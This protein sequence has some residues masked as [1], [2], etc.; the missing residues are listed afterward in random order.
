MFHFILKLLSNINDGRI[1]YVKFCDG[2]YHWA[3]LE[4]KSVYGATGRL[5][6]EQTYTSVP[7]KYEYEAHLVKGYYLPFPLDKQ[8]KLYSE[9]SKKILHMAR[10]ENDRLCE[11]SWPI[12]NKQ[13]NLLKIRWEREDIVYTYNENGDLSRYNVHGPWECEVLYD[14]GLMVSYRFDSASGCCT[15]EYEYDTKKRIISEKIVIHSYDDS[16]N[17]NL[18]KTYEYDEDDNLIRANRSDGG[19]ELYR[20]I[21]EYKNGNKVKKICRFVKSKSKKK[22]KILTEFLQER[23]NRQFHNKHSFS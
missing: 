6:Q 8:I 12:Y 2:K 21:F 17:I 4:E 5:I 19:V 18:C 14:N 1:L 11:E 20:T 13:Q 22:E 10:Y 23:A 15:T 7:Y 16:E 9:D 3:R